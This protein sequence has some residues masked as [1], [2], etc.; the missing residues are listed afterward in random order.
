[1]SIGKDIIAG[2]T[3]AIDHAQ[4][5]TNNVVVHHVVDVADLRHEL[6][7]TQA[8]FSSTYHIPLSTLQKWEAGTR[9]PKG[10]SMAYLYAIKKKPHI[11]KSIF[12]EAG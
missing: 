9:V 8:E 2:L 4:G 3:D 5:L 12:Q 11:V 1:M 10:A 6:D 7:L